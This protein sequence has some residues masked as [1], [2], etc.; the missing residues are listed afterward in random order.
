MELTRNHYLMIG[1]VLLFLGIQLRYVQTVTLNEQTTKFVNQQLGSGQS[2]SAGILA[3]VGP[4]PKRSF[5]P[6]PTI[7]FALVSIGAVITLH[8]L[9]MNK[10]AG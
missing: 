5:T 2:N 1:V 7:G 8:S 6:S 4:A 10:P 9:A 3:S